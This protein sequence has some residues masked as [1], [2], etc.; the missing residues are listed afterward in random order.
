MSPFGLSELNR[1]QKNAVFSE[2]L[3]PSTL[4]GTRIRTD[5]FLVEERQAYHYKGQLRISQ[6]GIGFSF[7][8]GDFFESRYI[9]YYLLS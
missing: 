2:K 1:I 3:V 9:F 6:E 8:M 4:N 5:L 7:W